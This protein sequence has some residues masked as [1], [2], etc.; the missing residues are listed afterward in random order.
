MITIRLDDFIIDQD[1][2]PLF[3]ID[4]EANILVI[5]DYGGIYDRI[6]D[7][8]NN[9]DDQ[10]YFNGWINGQEINGTINNLVYISSLNFSDT[11]NAIFDIAKQ[12]PHLKEVDRF[13]HYGL[14]ANL[15]NIERIGTYIG[16]EFFLELNA[17]TLK[18]IEGNLYNIS[19]S[20]FSK[21]I[22]LGNRGG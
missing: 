2:A 11:K 13:Y 21:D 17:I 8:C 3:K 1:A 19:C 5:T 16:I 6:A 15:G 20:N 18:H 22:I 7:F 10:V 4:G 14:P 12:L 9:V